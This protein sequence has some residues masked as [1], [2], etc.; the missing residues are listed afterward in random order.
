[1]GP[2]TSRT[3]PPLGGYGEAPLRRAVGT[4]KAKKSYG[5]LP[6]CVFCHKFDRLG[7]PY[8]FPKGTFPTTMKCSPDNFGRQGPL[9]TSGG[10]NFGRTR[11]LTPFSDSYNTKHSKGK[12]KTTTSWEMTTSR[13]DGGGYRRERLGG[14]PP[15]WASHSFLHSCIG[16][17]CFAFVLPKNNNA[18]LLTAICLEEINILSSEQCEAKTKPNPRTNVKCMVKTHV[19]CRIH[20]QL[21]ACRILRLGILQLQNTPIGVRELK[22]NSESTTKCRLARKK[23]IGEVLYMLENSVRCGQICEAK[24]INFMLLTNFFCDRWWLGGTKNDFFVEKK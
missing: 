2:H 13:K 9:T 22:D 18:S 17:L 4:R 10:D 15:F 3:A 12:N 19:A 24:D 20:H 16:L 1:M 23:S 8:N 11:V 7:P 21:W 5:N 14:F 6:R